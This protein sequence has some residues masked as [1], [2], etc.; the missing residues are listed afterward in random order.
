M[1]A[2]CSSLLISFYLQQYLISLKQNENLSITGHRKSWILQSVQWWKKMH[3]LIIKW[4]PAWLLQKLLKE[5]SS[6]RNLELDLR[7]ILVECKVWV[8]AL[9]GAATWRAAK[10][11]RNCLERF[12]MWCCRRVAVISWTDRVGNEEVL[13]RIA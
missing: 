9:C 13:Q 5:V 1:C 11:Y 8:T 12:E 6:I 2:L 10:V 7:Q 3:D 4:N